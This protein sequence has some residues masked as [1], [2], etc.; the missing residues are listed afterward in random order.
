MQAARSVIFVV[1]VALGALLL[2]AGILKAH[3]GPVAT[4]TTIAGYRL[5]PPGVVT[6]LGIALPYAEIILGVYLLAGLFTRAAAVLASLQF[7]VFSG[8]VA[9]LVVRRL[10]ADCGCFGSGIRTPP[11]WGHVAAD[12]VLMVAAALV[13]WRAPGA[14]ALDRLLFASPPDSFAARGS[15]DAADADANVASQPEARGAARPRHK[16]FPS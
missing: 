1:R 6:P 13:A 10:P 11:S 15:D 14:F 9:S 5:L 4:A 8:A 7:A 12:V 2:V 3:D 16:A